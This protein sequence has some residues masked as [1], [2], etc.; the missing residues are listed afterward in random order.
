MSLLSWS[1]FP[2]LQ[3][4]CKGE[5][6]TLEAL[7]APLPSLSDGGGP[8][9]VWQLEQV[10]LLL[11]Q[12]SRYQSHS[13]AA[14][15]EVSQAAAAGLVTGHRDRWLPTSSMQGYSILLPALDLSFP[16]VA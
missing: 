9:W 11:F 14:P 13:F 6:R 12:V 3:N 5:E 16:P 10:I 2:S 8:A 1:Q 15:G 7:R 4:G